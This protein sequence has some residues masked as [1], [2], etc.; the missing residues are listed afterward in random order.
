MFTS[1]NESLGLILRLRLPQA[2]LDYLL[3]D[4]RYFYSLRFCNI[5]V[6][7]KVGEF[8]GKIVRQEV[9]IHYRVFISPVWRLLL[10]VET[11]RSIMRAVAAALAREI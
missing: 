7:N 2:E 9:G 6:D 11:D 8:L 5:V 10:E 3:R 1:F 4:R